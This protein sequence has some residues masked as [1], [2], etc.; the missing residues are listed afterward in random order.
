MSVSLSMLNT[1]VFG[2]DSAKVYWSSG[3]FLTMV[4]LG[5]RYLDGMLRK[6]SA[7]SFAGLYQLQERCLRAKL[8]PEKDNSR[9]GRAG[10]VVNAMTLRPMD[11]IL[12]EPGWLIPCDSYVVSGESMVDQSSMTGEHKPALKRPGDQLLSGTVNL[13]SPIVADVLGTQEDSAL[14]ELISSITAATETSQKSTVL[15]Q[16]TSSFVQLILIITI[17]SFVWNMSFARSSSSGFERLNAALERAMAVLASACPCALGLATPSATL[18][19]LDAAYLRGIIVTRGYETFE[20]LARLTHIVLDKTGTLTTG[21]LSVSEQDHNLGLE[22]CL[23]IAIAERD[24]A[25]SHPVAQAVFKWAVQALDEDNRCRIST[26]KVRND[27]VKSSGIACEI[28][29]EESS[30]WHSVKIGN[31]SFLKDAGIHL[32]DVRLHGK[33]QESVVHVSIDGKH[34]A[35]LRLQDTIRPEAPGVIYNLKDRRNLKLAMLTGDIECEAQ[36]VSGALGIEVLS[37]Q[38]MPSQKRA[39]VEGVRT[40]STKNVVAMIGDGLNDAAAFSAADVGIFLSPGRSLAHSPATSTNLQTSNV[41]IMSPNLSRVPE[42]LEI[43]KL[44]TRQAIAV[45]EA[46]SSCK[47]LQAITC[48]PPNKRRAFT[49][50]IQLTEHSF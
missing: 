40:S 6:R 8:Y 16:M 15:D 34:F 22:Q 20:K 36:R 24:A 30:R 47:V 37:S 17:S 9:Q 26:A 2:L 43:A 1:L 38:V 46:D 29:P 12:I 49:F 4:I 48:G 33:V 19:G 32:S 10:V 45:A 39:C 44:T 3:V 35:S 21:A 14:E 31:A 7:A 50:S 42:L 13:S 25:S 28:Q 11:R 5:G 41:I 18:A 27:Y 23:L